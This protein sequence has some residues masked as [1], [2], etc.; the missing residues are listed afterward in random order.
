MKMS[1]VFRKRAYAKSLGV[2]IKYTRRS[3]DMP[4]IENELIYRVW[5]IFKGVSVSE[6][7]LYGKATKKMDN[8]I[9]KYRI[10]K[11]NSDN[12]LWEDEDD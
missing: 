12:K 9:F 2:K 11:V 3:F 1:K 8:E 7:T 4:K 6:Y 5:V 10:D